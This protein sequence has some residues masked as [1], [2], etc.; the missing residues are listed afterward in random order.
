MPM[1][2]SESTSSASLTPFFV[3]LKKKHT[4]PKVTSYTAEQLQLSTD[5][6]LNTLASEVYALQNDAL[7]GNENGYKERL[8]AL[9]VSL[10]K[11]D[12]G[13]R[14]TKGVVYLTRNEGET[15]DV[16]VA[17][18]VKGNSLTWYFWAEGAMDQYPQNFRD[19][20]YNQAAVCHKAVKNGCDLYYRGSNSIHVKAMHHVETESG[21]NHN[22][23]RLQGNRHYT[24]EDVR[25][26]MDGF[27]GCPIDHEFFEANEVDEICANFERF[28]GDW[29][30]KLEGQL[31]KEEQYFAQSSQR[32]TTGDMVELY[33]FG[34]KQEPCRLDVTELKV[35]YEAAREAIENVIKA[36]EASSESS[37]DTKS[38]ADLKKQLTLVEHEYQELL[39]FRQL[40]GTRGLNSAVASSRQVEGSRNPVVRA[41]QHMDDSIGKE[42]PD[43]PKWAIKLTDAVNVARDNMIQSA[44]AK[45]APGPLSKADV[46]REWLQLAPSAKREEVETMLSRDLGISS[47]KQVTEQQADRSHQVS[48]PA[49]L[50][51]V[52]SV[53]IAA[54]FKA[55]KKDLKKLQDDDPSLSN[56][57]GLKK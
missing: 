8:L 53:E 30:R 18:Q 16:E 48:N 9:T 29:T 54:K 52:P 13:F 2:P 34:E 41:R 51:E 40:G 44:K 22:H 11:D 55:M 47:L 27:K 10:K 31:S 33:L 42:V 37:D 35:D 43:I 50:N 20:L 32:F 15:V 3:K 45:H 21:H 46:A 6:Q 4:V 25:Q 7:A 49:S 5:P 24:P 1:L 57:T 56:E 38:I 17:L 14:I 36:K 28:H 12:I 26:H 19:K 23:Y 39:A